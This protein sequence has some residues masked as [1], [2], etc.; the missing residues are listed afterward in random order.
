MPSPGTTRS[1]RSEVRRPLFLSG[2][3]GHLSKSVA[4][5]EGQES[6]ETPAN[7][8]VC[9]GLSHCVAIVEME[10][11]KGFESVRGA[12]AH[13]MTC[14]NGPIHASRDAR[15][16]ARCCTDPRDFYRKLSQKSGAGSQVSWQK[17]RVT[18]RTSVWRRFHRGRHLSDPAALAHA[19]GSHQDSGRCFRSLY[20]RELGFWFARQSRQHPAA[21]PTRPYVGSGRRH[22]W[23]GR[24][25]SRQPPISAHRYQAPPG[26]RPP[27]RRPKTN[28]QPVNG[29]PAPGVTGAEGCGWLA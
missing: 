12:V 15:Q 17:D 21:S 11:A 23:L 7:G 14:K 13:A 25:L 27:H 26:G 24:L 29:F 1:P 16:T 22:W 10:R 5:G 3:A 28:L 19:L 20:P 8:G 4:N 9:H 2:A 6:H 18:F